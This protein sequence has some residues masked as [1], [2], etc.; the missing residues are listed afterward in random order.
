[1]Y[2]LY[3]T[4]FYFRNIVIKRRVKKQ[5]DL[6]IIANISLHVKNEIYLIRV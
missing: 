6:Q 3:T 1:M 2:P 5:P 4:I